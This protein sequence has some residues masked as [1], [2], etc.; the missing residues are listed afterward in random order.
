MNYLM[1]QLNKNN[2]YLAMYNLAHI[3]I[4]DEK[5]KQNLDEPI[6]L[7]IKSSNFFDPS[8]ILLCVVLIKYK[9]D[10]SIVK[11]KI[12]ELV[13]ENSELK[14]TVWLLIIFFSYRNAYVVIYESYRNKDFLYNIYFKPMLRSD[15]KS[16]KELNIPPKY[17]N[18]KNISELF[19]EGFGKD[20][21][22]K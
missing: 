18:A 15:L 1:R 21:L 17:P 8:L 12:E 7:L 22:I 14:I 10:L 11:N 20:L 3:Y 9:Y 13:H 4:Y 6:D 19:Y 5:I 16:I 2:D